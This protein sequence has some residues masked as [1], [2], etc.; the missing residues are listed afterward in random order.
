[1]FRDIRSHGRLWPRRPAGLRENLLAI[2]CR[3][4]SVV[5]GPAARTVIVALLAFILALRR[6]VD[7]A[8]FLIVLTGGCG[9]ANTALKHV[10]GRKRPN[11]IPLVSSGRSPSFPS[12]HASGSIALAGGIAAIG[13]KALGDSVARAGA[14]AGLALSVVLIGASRVQ[15]GKH[16]IGDVVGGYALGALWLAFTLRFL[17]RDRQGK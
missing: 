16:H 5:G 12:G 15:L 8:R 11:H 10:V 13:W 6:R 1:V 2:A 7:Q 14:L 17:R 9:I 3:M 4:A